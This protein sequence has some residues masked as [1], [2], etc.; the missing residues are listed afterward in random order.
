MCIY[1]STYQLWEFNFETF[2]FLVTTAKIKWNQNNA[3]IF[4]YFSNKLKSLTFSHLELLLANFISKFHKYYSLNSEIYKY[5][6]ETYFTYS[7]FHWLFS[8]I[9]RNI[10]P[11]KILHVLWIVKFCRLPFPSKDF[12]NI[13]KFTCCSRSIYGWNVVIL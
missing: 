2:L 9:D 8:Q 10:L 5:L 3:I 1:S 4:I 12:R 7:L 6:I 13:L 11:M